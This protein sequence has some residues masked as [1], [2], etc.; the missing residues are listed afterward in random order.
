ME[1]LHAC[2]DKIYTALKEMSRIES[3]I[4]NLQDNLRIQWKIIIVENNNPLVLP[5]TSAIQ[6]DIHGP[7]NTGREKPEKRKPKIIRRTIGSSS[8]FS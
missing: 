5:S 2:E 7:P 8:L 6:A 1:S 4:R 3:S